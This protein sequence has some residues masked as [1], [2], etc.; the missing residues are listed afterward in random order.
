[1]SDELKT[2][3]APAGSPNAGATGPQAGQPGS[4]GTPGDATISK[5]QYEA[6]EKKLGEQGKELGDYRSFV[7]NITPLLDKLDAQPELIQA[8]LDG[9]IDSELAK[10]A[11]QGKVSLGD[12]QKVSDAHEKVKKDMGTNY[13]KTA[14]ADIEKRVEEELS[15]VTADFDKKLKESEEMRNFKDKVNVFISNTEDFATYAEEIEE[16]IL[17][18][19]NID[20]IEMAYHV[21][22]GKHLQEEQV[23]KAEE[24][25]GEA[26][27]DL[28]ANAAGGYS[29]GGKLVNDQEVIDKL[30]SHKS[31]PNIF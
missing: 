26:A 4:A 31:N 23:K 17:N 20:D 18:N 5:D 22:K 29:Q 11:M 10:A 19:P 6:L 14:P 28:A 7:K 1:M 16:L 15:K 9:K 27:K 2:G 21:I 13:D 30:I 24:T 8:I 12:A 3:S 25:A